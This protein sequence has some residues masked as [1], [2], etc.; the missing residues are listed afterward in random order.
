MQQQDKRQQILVAAGD[1]FAARGF[2]KATIEQI[3][4]AAGVGKG[5]VYLY[6]K[7]KKGLFDAL[8]LE[9]FSMTVKRTKRALAELTDPIEHIRVIINLHLAIIKRNHPLMQMIMHELAPNRLQDLRS[10]IGQRVREH[11]ALYTEVLEQGIA[12]GCLRPHEPQIVAFA[13][14]GAINHIGAGLVNDNLKLS[15]EDCEQELFQLFIAGLQQAKD[16]D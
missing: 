2:H 4:D 16:I 12:S 1:I 10:E 9:G 7:N 6:F 8:L 3:A 5:T 13:L 14:A 11:M 15:L